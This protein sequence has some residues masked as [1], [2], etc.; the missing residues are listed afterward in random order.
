M[1]NDDLVRATSLARE[2]VDK[3]RL[4]SAEVASAIYHGHI[5]VPE[6]IKEAIYSRAKTVF[7]EGSEVIRLLWES[8]TTKKGIC[9][10]ALHTLSQM[11]DDAKYIVDIA[12]EHAMNMPGGIDVSL[13]IARQ[14][15]QEG[16]NLLR[17]VNSILNKDKTLQRPWC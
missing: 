16:N 12:K 2:A 13:Y 15:I 11:R 5:K 4:A 1:E 9:L 7:N 8:K 3:Y 17:E 6:R 10:S 14:Y